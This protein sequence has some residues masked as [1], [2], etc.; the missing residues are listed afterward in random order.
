MSRDIDVEPAL[1][2][3]GEWLG[4]EEG[5]PLGIVVL[6]GTALLLMGIVERGTSDVDL[7]ALADPP[8]PETGVSGRIRPPDPLPERLE[9]GI[10]RVARDFRLPASWM[11]AG[12]ARIGRRGYRRD[13]RNDWI[14][15]DTVPCMWAW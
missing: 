3:L 2:A 6:G 1:T 8:G 9:E 14:G 7:L 15:D 10:E 11:N 4:R 5:E 13:S 12:P